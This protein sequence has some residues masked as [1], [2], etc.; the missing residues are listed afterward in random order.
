M[1]RCVTRLRGY[2]ASDH[3]TSGGPC[4]SWVYFDVI[5]HSPPNLPLI[6]FQPSGP[7]VSLTENLGVQGW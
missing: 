2:F 7:D 1:L 5:G 4:I 6:D 3:E